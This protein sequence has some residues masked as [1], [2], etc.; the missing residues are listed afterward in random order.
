MFLRVDVVPDARKEEVLEGKNGSLIL[1]VKE[2]A[3]GNRANL[4]VRELVSLRFQVPFAAVR[5]LT[6][7]HSRSKL[8]TID[9]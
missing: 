4:R 1:R 2:P 9:N 7:H 8:L 3:E 6:G 5:I